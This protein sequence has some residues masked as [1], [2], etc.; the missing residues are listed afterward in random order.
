MAARKA[1]TI[2]EE[3]ELV[4]ETMAQSAEGTMGLLKQNTSFASRVGGD[5]VNRYSK[6]GKYDYIGGCSPFNTTRYGTD[7]AELIKL[8]KIC[9]YENQ[10]YRN[11]ILTLVQLSNSKLIVRGDDKKIENF[12]KEW[13]KKINVWD[14]CNQ[15]FTEWYRSGNVFI[16]KQLETL[17]LNEIRR[18][19]SVSK[20]TIAKNRK[21]PIKYIILDPESIRCGGAANLLNQVYSKLLNQ[22]EIER[23]KNPVDGSAEDQF[24]SSL[25]PS[26]RKDIKEGKSPEVTF[27]PENLVAV[28][29][30]KQAYEPLAVPTFSPIIKQINLKNLMLQCDTIMWETIDMIILLINCGDEKTGAKYNHNIVNNITALMSNRGANRVIIS[31]YTT[32]AQFVVPDL[33]KVMSPDRYKDLDRDI[34]AGLMDLFSLSDNFSSSFVKIKI[35][36]ELLRQGQDAF[37]TQFLIPEMESIADEMGWTSIPKVQFEEVSLESDNEMMKQFVRL[38]ELGFLTGEG[39]ELAFNNKVLPLS[40]NNDELQAE[41]KRAKD[42]GLYQPIIGGTKDEAGRPTGTTKKQTKTAPKSPAGASIDNFEGLA[43]LEKIK[44]NV[45]RMDEV[46]NLVEAEYKKKNGLQRLYKRHKSLSDT[47]AANIIANEPPDK[48]KESVSEYIDNPLVVNITP[49]REGILELMMEYD[50]PVLAAA[51]LYHGMDSH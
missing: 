1:K 2:A 19:L 3:T 26:Q 7:I 44:S 27:T 39:L 11:S 28:F 37:L 45:A 12:Y 34:S 48:W 49:Q 46:F 17:T 29:N 51:M 47:V 32:K 20:E 10:T 31:D 16:Y 8:S 36:L 21:S 38:Y 25:T 41:F 18:R 40:K 30:N 14:L 43:S 5:V 24:L 9:F 6:V 33:A 22:Y 23:L 4:Y 42:K 15:F 13:L 35:Y 50:L